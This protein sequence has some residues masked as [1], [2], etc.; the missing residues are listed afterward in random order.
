METKKRHKMVELEIKQ[1][2]KTINNKE[3]KELYD[4]QKQLEKPNIKKPR[5]W[6]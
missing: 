4:L 5:M 6:R 2:N 3:R 1:Y